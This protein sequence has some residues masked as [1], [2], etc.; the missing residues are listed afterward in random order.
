MRVDTLDRNRCVDVLRLDSDH[1]AVGNSAAVRATAGPGTTTKHAPMRPGALRTGSERTCSPEVG[2]H[3][4][5][6]RSC[7]VDI[8]EP[9]TRDD[10]F[11]DGEGFLVSSSRSSHGR[12]GRQQV[13]PP[14]EHGILSYE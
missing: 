14:T 5:N 3:S 13:R 10:C 7:L 6:A 4:G 9:S 12:A 11:S 2:D 8:S 1:L